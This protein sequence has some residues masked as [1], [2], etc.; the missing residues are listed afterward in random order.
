[1]RTQ[2][3][4]IIAS[5]L[6]FSVC[7]SSCLGSEEVEDYSTDATIHA[8]S[9]DTIHGIDYKFEIDHIKN[10]IYNLD[11]LPMDADTII[12]SILVTMTV[13]FTVTSAD[14]VFNTENHQDL[15]PA[16]NQQGQDGIKFKVY[17][18]D[19]LTTRDYV[20]QVRVHKQDPD[21][22]EWTKLD[23]LNTSAPSTGNARKAVVKDGELLLYTSA[24]EMYKTST[25]PDAYG[26]SGAIAVSGLPAEADITSLIQFSGDLY[27]LAAGDVYTS[28]DGVTWQKNDA[29]SGNVTAL[30]ASLPHD[31]VT[32]LQ[33]TLSAIRQNADN[34]QSF[35]TTTDGQTWN[36]GETV[37]QGFP[38]QQLQYTIETNRAGLNKAVVVGLPH[39]DEK[40]TIPWFTTDGKGWG[41]LETTADNKWCPAIDRPMLT[42]YGGNYHLFGGQ[43]DTIYSSIA[44]IAWYGAD[45]KFRLPAEFEGKTDYT[46]VVEP[47]EDPTVSAA[48]KRDF[49]WVI[50]GGN[51]TENEV[52]RGRLNKLGFERQ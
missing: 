51:S 18:P 20:L 14:T 4:S 11:S 25:A 46:I 37:P 49:I 48:D 22:L 21:S 42:Y 3:L 41:S 34:T 47:T 17:A 8:F 13:P 32:G 50:F 38:T 23:A 52:W 30:V 31:K 35:C 29:L 19:G 26:W 44:G 33:P 12:D 24:T 6:I 1:M 10:L 43:M 45:K 16:M 27:M 7:I 36:T 40:K 2:F 15:L 28:A 39:A 9:L 5:F